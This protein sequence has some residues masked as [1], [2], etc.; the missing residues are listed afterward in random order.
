[1]TYAWSGC[2]SGSSPNATCTVTGIGS[3][4]ANVTVN[5]GW[6]TGSAAVGAT[7]T[8]QTPG[9]TCPFSVTMPAG[10][11]ETLTWNV[12][13]DD[14]QHTCTVTVQQ[15]SQGPQLTVYNQ[16]C[17][18]VELHSELCDICWG[19]VVMRVTDPWG[20]EDDC[21]IRIYPRSPFP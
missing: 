11:T 15:P 2:A 1:M 5:D 7:G 3:F 12:N 6:A 13:D 10:S 8:N 4:A 17:Y 14:T 20:A 9:V 21:G 19:Y 16:D 18:S